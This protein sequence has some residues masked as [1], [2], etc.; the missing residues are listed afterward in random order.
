MPKKKKM[1]ICILLDIERSLEG[2]TKKLDKKWLPLGRI[3]WWWMEE[4]GLSLTKLYLLKCIPC[5]FSPLKK[6]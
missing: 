3:L 1:Y 4:E 5:E 6:K 2:C